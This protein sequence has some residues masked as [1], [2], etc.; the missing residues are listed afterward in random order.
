MT[1]TLSSP[2]NPIAQDD[3]ARLRALAE[4]GRIRPLL[5]GREL[6]LYGIAIALAAMLHALIGMRVLAWPLWSIA[7]VWLVIMS[8]TGLVTRAARASEDRP[9]PA[10]TAAL[11]ERQVWQV[12]GATLGTLA[13]SI[14]A[15]AYLALS[16]GDDTGFRLFVL[17]P[18]VVFGVYAIAMAASA[19]AAH[20]D[21]LRPFAVLSIAFLVATTLLAGSAW[22]LFA[23]ALGGIVV[24]VVPGMLLLRRERDRG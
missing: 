11:V 9:A 18:P 22:Q 3:L 23:T 6:V 24:S 10:T 7:A 2:A 14:L 12:A 16:R 1:D 8:A 20:S 15:Y 5:G 4:E 17:M 21:A 19:T 13:L